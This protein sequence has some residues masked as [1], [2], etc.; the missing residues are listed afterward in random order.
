MAQIII[1]RPNFL[2]SEE[3]LVLKSIS[4]YDGMSGVASVTETDASGYAHKV[5]KAG[6]VYTNSTSGM[7]GLI[8]EDIDVSVSSAT[9]QVPA[10]LMV[11][12]HYINDASVLPAVVSSANDTLFKGQG[13][14][15]HKKAVVTRPDD[16]I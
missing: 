3:G 15:G 2:Y 10:S 11:A 12:G 13:L 7:N 16:E 9:E 1:N 8:F 4:V 6:T 5:I 14:F